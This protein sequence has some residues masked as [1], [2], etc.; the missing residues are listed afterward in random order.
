[1]QNQS[2]KAL[3]NFRSLLIKR[4]TLT[5]F[6]TL[7]TFTLILFIA[8]PISAFS[9]KKYSISGYVR[10]KESRE[11]LPGVNIYLPNLKVG[12]IT[13]NYGFYSIVLPEGVYEVVYSF[14]GYDHVVQSIELK[15]N[16][17]VDVELTGITLQEVVISGEKGQRISESTDM[18]MISLP[19][20]QIKQLPSLL[21][22]KDVFKALQLLPGVQKGSEGN[23]GIYVRGGGP[24]Q[25]LII[26]DDAPVYNASHL[27]GF[28]SIFNGDAL[29]SVELI[30][31]GF[32][33]RY[34]GRLSSVIEMT[35]KDGNKQKFSGEAGIGLISSR[36]VLEGPI[37]KNVSSFI[38]SGRRTYIDA[39]IRPF[40]TREERAGYYFYD[41]NAKVNYDIGPKDRVY[42][43]GYFGR[44][45]FNV[46]TKYGDN[47][48][49]EGGLYWQN[50]T[51][52]AR[53]NHLF[54][55]RVFSNTSLI[56]SQYTLSIYNY[57]K[58]NQN[59][60]TL[61]YS[62]GIRD[63]SAKYDLEYNA[64][65]F[66]HLKTGFSL[67]NHMFAP[68]AIVERDDANQV[69]KN[70]KTNYESLEGGVYLENN[71][72]FSENLKA[73]AGV[74]LSTFVA[75][76][77]NYMALEPRFVMN[78]RL[79]N[80]LS[81]KAGY[82][83]MN[84]YIHLLSN[85]GIGLP[86]DLWVPSTTRVEPQHSKQISAGIAKD[87][88]DSDVTVTVEGYYKLSDK[89]LGYKPG[90]SFLA[91]DDPTEAEAFTWEDN[92]TAG[93]G[94]SYGAEFLIHKKTGKL[95]GWVGYTLSW[96]KLKFDELNFGKEFWARYDRRHDI[97]V[98]AIYNIKPSINFS[99]TWVYGTGNAITLPLG[100]YPAI[101]HNPLEGSGIPTGSSPWNPYFN[102]VTDYGEMNSSRMK[103]YHR[104]DFA[105]QFIKIRER[106]QRTWEVGFYNAYNRKNPFF[107]FIDEEYDN[108]T[109]TTKLKQVSIF[110]VIPS[111]TYS[112]KF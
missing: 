73:N 96:T 66:Y 27:F 65:P 62:S 88:T 19:V 6:T 99:A 30:K 28:F 109:V 78:L 1:M 12:T 23:S 55:S 92:V 82:A 31:G 34:G 40:M 43:S 70:D 47:E 45:K 58:E 17:L 84:Q 2:E 29:K 98:V 80:N 21:G 75:D 33:A 81:V 105:F 26:L 10:E 60:Y 7:L 32:P 71:L 106:Y 3:L 69:Y 110:P 86:T 89:I 97:S 79:M 46:V 13:N 57:T 101:T 8:L 36:L 4:P 35:M 111:V 39:L 102:Y 16:K 25:N 74:R 41:L 38:V 112:I 18:S 53:W 9:Q 20:Q 63:L 54:G 94:T 51:A 93:S 22:E 59:A 49:E 24:D 15:A 108:N 104:L 103:P 77:K 44:D 107:Y 37:K 5:T 91:L 56:Y 85:T 87:F 68:R 95:N 48:R 72:T 90:A 64:S 76:N 52:T 61:K 83:E 11:L 50:A 14:V 42:L 100:D 67:T